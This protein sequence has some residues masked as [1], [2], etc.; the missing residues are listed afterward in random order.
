MHVHTILTAGDIA[1]GTD[2]ADGTQWVTI[3]LTDQAVIKSE[4]ARLFRKL[5]LDRLRRRIKSGR[6]H[7]PGSAVEIIAAMAK[8]SE[9]SRW[10]SA[11]RRRLLVF[12]LQAVGS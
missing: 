7:D 1:Q 2:G 9:W 6:I 4:A 5:L 12:C 3:P 10:C 11:F 8:H